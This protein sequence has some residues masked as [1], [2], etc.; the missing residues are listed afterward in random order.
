MC[1]KKKLIH[2]DLLLLNTINSDKF[3]YC[4]IKN[5][6]KLIHSQLT[7]NHNPIEI[8]KRCLSYFTVKSKKLKIHKKYCGKYTP[9]RVVMP[10]DNNI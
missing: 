10:S 6:T 7:K 1:D 9:T 8:C 3:H 2:F 5:F 4:Y